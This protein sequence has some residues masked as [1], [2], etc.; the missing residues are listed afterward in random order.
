MD[1]DDL[2]HRLRRLRDDAAEPDAT[3]WE[4]IRDLTGPADRARVGRVLAEVPAGRIVGDAQPLEPLRVAVTGTFT[5]D[6][7]LPLVRT[8]MLGAGIDAD[9]RVSG[10]GQLAIGLG[11]PESSLARACPQVTLCVLHEGLL[12][13]VDWNPADLSRLE[14]DLRRRAEELGDLVAGYAGRTGS[15]VLLHTVPLP[16]L[17]Y[18]K[19]VSQ[20]GRAAL[21]KAW[22]R[23]NIQLLELPEHY[24][25]VHVVDLD[26]LFQGEAVALRDDRRYHY[27]RMAWSPALEDLYA[28]ET[29]SF[30]RGLVGRASKVLVLDLDDTLWGGAVGDVGV[31]GIELGT[32]YPGNAYLELQRCAQAFQRQGV[33]L[34]IA[35]KNDPDV[36]DQVLTHHP[37]LLLRSQDFAA[38]AVN[39]APKS[40]NLR[41]LAGE[42]N[43]SPD[44]FVLVDDNPFECGLVRESLPAVRI[45]SADGDPSEVPRRLLQARLF[46]VPDLTDT[47]L[48]RTERH[49]AE[50]Q[51]R[52]SLDAATSSAAYLATLG[53]E[54][55]VRRADAYVLPRVAQ[56]LA[57]TNQ[58][59]TSGL[60]WGVGELRSAIGSDPG[61]VLVFD[62]NDRFGTE[63]CVGALLLAV[64]AQHWTITNMVMS[65]RVFS[66]GI[67]FAVLSDV[68]R[69]AVAAG[70][71][72]LLAQVTV[73]ARNGPAR[74][75][76]DDAGFE[77]TDRAGD[78]RLKL[79]AH[80]EKPEWIHVRS[81]DE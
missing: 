66:R 16:I 24:S 45:V 14:E 69:R 41:A 26:V 61:S 77:P 11:D 59:N 30:C 52:V 13:P 80:V 42:L 2:V 67:E 56:L 48:R 68:C 64:D 65:C 55:E 33:L 54:V 6:G 63:D 35:S 9:V 20:R 18:R 25:N 47:D 60:R 19:L 49:R 62:V 1:T 12:L 74:R 40:E 10:F 57:R 17:D 73:T 32:M 37:N 46:D 50:R 27:A 4:A 78:R 39:W 44:S 31:D 51:R 81:D 29:A 43:V 72:E 7:F 38:T 5:T 76:L 8:A 53:L 3:L 34:A 23:A 58:F 71:A 70:A 22:R 15:T 28:Q 36:V 75:F 21:A 79:P